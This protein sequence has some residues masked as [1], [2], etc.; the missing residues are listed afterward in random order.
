MTDK[1]DMIENI[2]KIEIKTST[3]KI[4]IKYKESERP[5][6]IHKKDDVYIR[7]DHP[8]VHYVKSKTE[9]DKF[10]MVIEH[11]KGWICTCE[12]WQYTFGDCKHIREIKKRL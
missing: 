3:G 8:S 10:Y 4:F 2:E 9:T 12:C 6:I 5:H 7:V 1:I 11:D